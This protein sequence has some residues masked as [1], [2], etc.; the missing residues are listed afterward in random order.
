MAAQGRLAEQ[1]RDTIP[2]RCQSAGVAG[3]RL[4]LVHSRRVR[5]FNAL[6]G[7]VGAGAANLGRPR[8][9]RRFARGG[10]QPSSEAEIRVAASGPRARCK[11]ARGVLRLSVWWPAEIAWAVGFFPA[12]GR[13]Y[14]ECA[15]RFVGFFAFCYFAKRGFFPGRQGTLV[16]VFD[17]MS[18]N[19]AM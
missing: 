17:N 9:R 8:A 3:I 18:N 14:V 19:I 1:H 16:A 12:L 6:V 7:G 2:K 13:D 5:A 15:L 11:F 4:W 10:V